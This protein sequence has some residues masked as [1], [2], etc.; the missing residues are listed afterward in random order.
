MTTAPEDLKQVQ[1]YAKDKTGQP[2]SSLGIIHAT[3][4]GGGYHEGED[5]LILAGTAPGPEYPGSDYSYTD[6]P[7]DL[8]PNGR[9]A[10]GNNASGFDWGG[11]F[12]GFHGFNKFIEARM[13]ANDPRLRDVRE[14]IYTTDGKTVKRIDRTGK[15]G[16]T[17]DASHLTHSHF[18]F[19][20][21][22]LGR[23]ARDDNFLG[24]VKEHF[25]GPAPQEDEM[26]Q[27]TQDNVDKMT[28]FLDALVNDKERIEGG[29]NKNKPN[30]V[31]ER[32]EEIDKQVEAIQEGLASLKETVDALPSTPVIDYRAFA[33]ALLDEMNDRATTNK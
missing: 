9:L 8:L 2:W 28:W 12:K 24:V 19:F 5:L 21:D 7:R 27:E 20:R 30:R 3:P 14:F 26:S 15:Q 29:F 17:G 10:G 16:N 11:D 18:S 6:S 31:H 23:R 22:S 13:R 1:V 33:A 32:F 25:E 4:Q